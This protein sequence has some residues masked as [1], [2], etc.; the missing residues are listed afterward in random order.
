LL[1]GS[2]LSIDSIAKKCGFGSASAMRRAFLS[3][4]GATPSDYRERFGTSGDGSRPTMA[5]IV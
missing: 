4:M 3:H 2:R 5:E 1:E